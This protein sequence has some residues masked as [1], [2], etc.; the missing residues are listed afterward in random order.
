ML[1]QFWIIIFL[2]PID[3]QFKNLFCA[4][5]RDLVRTQASHPETNAISQIQVLFKTYL[6]RTYAA[7]EMC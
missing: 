5:D 7:I 6:V 4:V 3:V 1:T 2:L